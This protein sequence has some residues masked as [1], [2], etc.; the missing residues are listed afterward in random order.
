MCE[1]EI[2]KEREDREGERR[3][4]KKR[5][6]RRAKSAR[7]RG[8]GFG[9]E[10]EGLVYKNRLLLTRG[11]LLAPDRARRANS[12]FAKSRG[13]RRDATRRAASSLRD[14]ASRCV[15]AASDVI[16]HIMLIRL[17]F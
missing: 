14:L 12:A 4:E 6:A 8:C 1:R 17:G 11:D 2:E 16:K 3:R 9:R 5:R 15:N 10:N 13:T 7:S